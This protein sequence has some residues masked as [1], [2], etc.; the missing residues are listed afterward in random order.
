MKQIIAV[1]II[2]FFLA[3]IGTTYVIVD[4]IKN[5]EITNL[6][7]KYGTEI[8]NLNATI[9]DNTKEVNNL[10]VNL[11]RYKII[12]TWSRSID[13]IDYVEYHNF[14]FYDNNSF[15]E[16]MVNESGIWINW[17]AFEISEVGCIYL[18]ETFWM[19]EYQTWK[20]YPG[21]GYYRYNFWYE[22]NLELNCPL[23]AGTYFYQRIE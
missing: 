17:G 22:P 3:T 20:E 19:K 13:R 23:C 15:K 16:E 2:L 12:G 1:I 21:E 10:T 14:T 5:Q 9:S 11:D 8:S 6:K 4:S 18:N 7:N